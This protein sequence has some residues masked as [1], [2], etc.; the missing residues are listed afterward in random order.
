MDISPIIN[1]LLQKQSDKIR[2]WQG[3]SFNK[4]QYKKNTN[5]LTVAMEFK[6]YR[7]RGRNSQKDWFKKYDGEFFAK[8]LTEIVQVCIVFY[9]LYFTFKPK[10]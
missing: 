7:K 10:T 6:D 4:L 9:I 1:E 8:C 3:P 2:D 5:K